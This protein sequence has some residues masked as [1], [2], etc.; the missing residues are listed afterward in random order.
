M[1]MDKCGSWNPSFAFLRRGRAQ[2]FDKK[3]NKAEEVCWEFTNFPTT[4]FAISPVLCRIEGFG[5]KA[6]GFGDG[7]MLK[8]SMI[9]AFA[10]A[11]ERLW[12]YRSDR[13]GPGVGLPR[14]TSSNG[15][16]AGRSAEDAIRRSK[17]ELIE[18]SV[19]LTA[20]RRMEGWRSHA[21]ESWSVKLAA[22]AATRR[23]WEIHFY[24]L[25]STLDVSLFRSSNSSFSGSSL[26]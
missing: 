20:W 2:F 23:G 9:Q 10:E 26:K 16:A 22:K 24:I 8:N 7:L 6:K 25:N 13:D 1:G 14:I 11:W 4:S 18:R 3:T 12:M 15:F 19:L 17:L 5:L 21:V